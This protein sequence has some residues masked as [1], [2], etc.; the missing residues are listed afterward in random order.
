MQ[1]FR[2][3]L[4]KNTKNNHHISFQ[5]KALKRNVRLNKI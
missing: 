1:A 5:N 3:L 4:A 2:T